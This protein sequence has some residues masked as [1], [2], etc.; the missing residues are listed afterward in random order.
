MNVAIVRELIKL[1]K[2]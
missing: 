1:V 2:N